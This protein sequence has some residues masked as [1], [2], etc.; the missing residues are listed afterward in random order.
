MGPTDIV[1]E[2]VA[3]STV[4]S[5]RV[6]SVAVP[7][8]QRHSGG[9]PCGASGCSPTPAPS[10]T[11]QNG[12]HTSSDRSWSQPPPG[13]TSSRSSTDNNETTP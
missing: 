11:T 4:L 1:A 13:R 12:A 9:K 8:Y 10:P 3:H 5:Q 2:A 7:I 6:A